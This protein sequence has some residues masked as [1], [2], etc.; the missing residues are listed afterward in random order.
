MTQ[1]QQPTARPVPPRTIPTSSGWLHLC[2]GL[3][4]KRDGGMVPSILGMTGALAK[5]GHDIT[6]VTPTPSSLKGTIVPP[7]VTLKGPETTIEPAVREADV[8]HMHGLWQGHTRRGSREARRFRVPYVIAAHGM[9]EPWALKHKALKKKVYTALIEGKNLRHAACLHALARPEIEHLRAL[10]PRTPICL[11]PNGVN[12]EPFDDLPDCSILAQEYPELNGKFV[13]LF[14]GRIHVKKGLDLLANA[15]KTIAASRPELH[16]LIA[17]NEDGALAP[18]QA[19]MA[20]HGL[21]DRYTYLGHVGGERSRQV[22]GAADAFIL[23]SYSEGFSMA[24]L[25]GLAARLPVVVTHSCHFPELARAE[26]GIVVD[27]TEQGVLDGMNTLLEQSPRERSE[28]AERGRLLVESQYTWERQAERL[29]E[30]YRWVSG[31]GPVPEPIEMAGGL[32]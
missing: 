20:S 5:N 29:A 1:L 16:I 2:N 10:A 11:V 19:A 31:G 28:M 17:G 12:L 8:V 13:V 26:G 30:V 15:M 32:R 14:Y 25:E 7:G 23:P 24:I 3:D 27:A 4:P 6:I 18:F 9:A 22:W 21:T